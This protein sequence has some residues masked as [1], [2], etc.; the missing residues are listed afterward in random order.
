M[1]RPL[2]VLVVAACFLSAC[3]TPHRESRS[4]GPTGLLNFDN[5]QRLEEHW[6]KHGMNTSEFNPTLAKE[7]YL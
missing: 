4:S 7:E 3:N 5:D 2:I 1:K 6:L